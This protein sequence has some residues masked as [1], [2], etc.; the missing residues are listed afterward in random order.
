M[1]QVQ[2]TP[3]SNGVC[4]V[5]P[6]SQDDVVDLL[7]G[8]ENSPRAY[9]LEKFNESSRTGAPQLSMELRLSCK[10]Q[11]KRQGGGPLTEGAVSPADHDHWTSVHHLRLMPLTPVRRF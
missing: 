2:L 4:A 3:E 11:H 5:V 8:H 1:G 7:H 6:V 9:T 10:R